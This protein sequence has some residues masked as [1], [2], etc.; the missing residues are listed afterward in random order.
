VYEFGYHVAWCPRYRRPV[1]AGRVAARCKDLIRA[2]ASEHSWRMVALEIIPDLVRLLVRAHLSDSPS[3]I[4]NQFTGLTSRRLRAEFP[5]LSALW[6][7]R[8]S[9]A[10]VGAVSA[11]TVRRHG[12]MQNERLWREERAR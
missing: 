11:E 1:L 3:R 2:K 12:G 9:A 6:S 8:Y 10:T 7:R 5:H 4:V